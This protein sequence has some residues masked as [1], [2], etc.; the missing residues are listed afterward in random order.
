MERRRWNVGTGPRGEGYAFP[1]CVLGP[2]CETRRGRK[3]RLALLVFE[4][5][6]GKFLTAR[7]YICCSRVLLRRFQL[8][9]I[10]PRILQ[11]WRGDRSID[12][13][14]FVQ[15]SLRGGKDEE[16]RTI[17]KLNCIVLLFVNRS[18]WYVVSH[19]DGYID[20]MSNVFSL[21]RVE[22]AE[23][24]EIFLFFFFVLFFLLNYYIKML[25]WRN[26]NIVNN[27]NRIK[28]HVFIAM[29]NWELCGYGWM[30][31][32]FSQA[33]RLLFIKIR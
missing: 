17:M 24:W 21:Q 10:P 23:S 31:N 8:Y 5:G 18:H 19:R 20:C 13:S 15:I 6:Y 33:V 25:S 7:E 3:R 27:G 11:L 9:A 14:R 2:W 28:C 16:R 22:I 30:N 29:L 1:P 26:N 4:N 32:N 12:R